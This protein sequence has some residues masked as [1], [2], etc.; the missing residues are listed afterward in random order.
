MQSVV[1]CGNRAEA[2]SEVLACNV[3]LLWAL[4][5]GG[6]GT[7]SGGVGGA[8]IGAVAGEVSCKS[9]VIVWD[10]TEDSLC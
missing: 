9:R 5:G 3:T 1:D 7:D 6:V 2:L 4:A 10:C 8:G